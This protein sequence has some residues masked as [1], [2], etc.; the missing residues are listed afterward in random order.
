MTGKTSMKLLTL[1]ENQPD[2]LKGLEN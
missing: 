2:K 1:N